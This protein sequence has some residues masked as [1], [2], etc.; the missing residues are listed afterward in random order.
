MLK[1]CGH[2]YYRHITA[3]VQVFWDAY[4]Q[5]F[6]HNTVINYHIQIYADIAFFAFLFADYD[7]N[8][9]YPGDKLLATT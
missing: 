2:L 6:C 5:Y 3:I 1:C 9:G 7:I 8:I 4:H